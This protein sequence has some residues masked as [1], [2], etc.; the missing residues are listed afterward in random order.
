LPQLQSAS[1]GGAG[2]GYGDLFAAAVV[3]G[4]LAVERGPQLAAALGL[5]AVSLAWDQLY[6]CTTFFPRPCRRRLS[7][8]LGKR[9]GR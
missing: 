1:F 4:V 9:G 2:L 3:G 6:R 8:S 5:L 7:C